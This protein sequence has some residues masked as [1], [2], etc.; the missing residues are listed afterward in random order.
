MKC[1]TGDWPLASVNRRSPKPI[2]V[3]VVWYGG[4]AVMVS[5]WVAPGASVKV[6]GETLAMMPPLL[7]C[8]N[9][10]FQVAAVW[11]AGWSRCA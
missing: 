2:A 8:E 3:I 7:L 1:C 5:T 11:R 4:A 6:A 9:E 10:V